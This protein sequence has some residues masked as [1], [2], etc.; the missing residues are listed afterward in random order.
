[1]TPHRWRRSTVA[2]GLAAALASAGASIPASAAAGKAHA[3]YVPLAGNAHYLVYA[4]ATSTQRLYPWFLNRYVKLYELGSS[5]E[6]KALGEA[7]PA[8][9]VFLVKSNLVV[10]SGDG[11]GDNEELVRWWDLSTDKSGHLQTKDPVVGA[12]PDGLLY[13]LTEGSVSVVSESYSGARVDFGDPLRPGVGYSVTV[14]PDGFVSAANNDED[15]DGEIVYVPWAHPGRDRVLQD[16]TG[17]T[18]IEPTCPV[19]ESVYVVCSTDSGLVQYPVHGGRPT[20]AKAAKCFRSV[21][22]VNSQLAWTSQPSTQ[23]GAPCNNSKVGELTASGTI[24]HSA[25]DY[26]Y[27]KIVTAFGRLVVATEGQR[28][29]VTL[30]AANA[31]P[32]I[33]SRSKV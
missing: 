29:L 12:T 32:G 18:D 13:E 8:A 23:S 33:L 19:V 17:A 10:V 26:D 31:A 20:A 4:E 30:R 16:S 3:R 1:M 25:R 27:T 22:M 28:E 5:G 24:E 9:E 2:I 21:T 11:A 7:G 14:G 15:G 6:P